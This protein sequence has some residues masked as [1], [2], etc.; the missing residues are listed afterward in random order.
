MTRS[1]TA[2][3]AR[4]RSRMLGALVLFCIGAALLQGGDARAFRPLETGAWAGVGALLGLQSSHLAGLLL[5]RVAGAPVV[6][7][8]G[9][10]PRLADLT[11]GGITL[12]LRRVPIPF[13]CVERVPVAGPRLRLR[14]WVATLL[15]SAVPITLGVLLVGGPGV[16]RALGLGVLVP[17]VLSL[18]AV[19][20]PLSAG[21]MLLRMPSLPRDAADGLALSPEGVSAMRAHLRGDLAK[22]GSTLGP[23]SAD[24]LPSGREYLLRAGVA[25]ARGRYEE[26]ATLA[27]AAAGALAGRAHTAQA[28]LQLAG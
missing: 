6:A 8:L 25:E 9:F 14:L 26:S 12:S 19:R 20:Q 13:L 27:R 22:A 21:W 18:V 3:P 23:L 5:G 1:S 2:D 16:G 15:L 10:G 24:S 17:P 7:V 11:V 28:H 4:T